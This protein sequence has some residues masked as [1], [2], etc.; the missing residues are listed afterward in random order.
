M[1]SPDWIGMNFEAHREL[2]QAKK[3]HEPWHHQS[4]RVLE[5]YQHQHPG[6][7]KHTIRHEEIEYN[8]MIHG[9]H[10]PQAH[11]IALRYEAKKGKENQVCQ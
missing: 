7:R 5:I 3:V 6:A 1:I 10:Y 11:K 8:M 4:R 9:M 2:K